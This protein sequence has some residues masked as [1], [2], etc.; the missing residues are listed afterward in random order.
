M[1]LTCAE[2]EAGS[3][4][5]VTSLSLVSVLISEDRYGLHL[6]SSVQLLA[7]EEF[8]C[9]IQMTLLQPLQLGTW[10]EGKAGSM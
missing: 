9:L 8:L 4:L 1:C 6:K 3:A 7:S 5:R 2:E 10:W